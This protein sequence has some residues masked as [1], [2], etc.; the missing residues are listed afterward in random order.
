MKKI[1]NL[2]I[3]SVLILGLAG[4]AFAQGSQDGIG[5]LHD[6]VIA[7]GGQNGSGLQTDVSTGTG[8]QGDASELQTQ[9]Q[10]QVRAGNYETSDGKQIQIQE[11]SNNQIELKSGNSKAETSLQ[12]GSKAVG[13]K[14]VLSAK[15]SNGRD[16]EVKVMPDTASETALERLRLKTCTEEAGCSIELKEVGKGDEAKLAY[17]VKTQRQS[18]IF[19]LFKAKMQVQAQVDAENGEVI[20]TSKP[21]WAFLASEPTEE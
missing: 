5:V 13:D 2:T 1:L 6:D 7:A 16:A 8:N 10:T 11:M 17:E 12:V 20:Q 15:L 18:K 4:F 3:M 19:G 14:T 21:W 9:V